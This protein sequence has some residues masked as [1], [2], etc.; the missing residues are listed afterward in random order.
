MFFVISGYVIWVSSQSKNGKSTAHFTY[1]R[2]TRIYLGFW[3]YF[4]ICLG[5]VYAF[6]PQR[7]EEVD[8]VGSFFLG[9]VIFP[10]LLLQVA[11]TLTYEL[12]FYICFAILLFLPKKKII[13]IIKILFIFIILIQGYHIFVNDIYS[14]EKLVYMDFY[15]AFL[16]SPFCLEFLMG[17]MIGIYF[18]NK[19]I[20]NISILA[21]LAILIF[22]IGLWYQSSY[23]PKGLISQGYY[24]PQRV[25]F[26]G[27]ISVLTVSIL[28]ELNKR[29]VVILE[30][31]SKLLGGA[32][33]SI[34]LAHIPV[35]FLFSQL[36]FFDY[37]TNR[38]GFPELA[39]VIVL[40]MV[41]TYSVFHYLYIEKSLMAF[42]KTIWQRKL[43]FLFSK[44]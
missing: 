6:T 44:S 19:R 2:L 12:Y 7:I 8:L 21:I 5:L 17:C 25:L 40:I 36:G 1:N 39:F 24:L 42:S 32:S 38:T 14:V 16:T 10:K 41:L 23:V 43:R 29:D 28:I 20:K 27:T 37:M 33:Y 22:I 3:P 4:L 34:Y 15:L 26:F 31:T 18:E 30:R 13:K 35:I 11:W 9:P